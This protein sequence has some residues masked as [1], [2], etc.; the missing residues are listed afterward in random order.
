MESREQLFHQVHFFE[1][2]AEQPDG[3]GIRDFVFD[4][5][6]E[7]THE[8]ETVAYLVFD[9]VVREVVQLLQHQYLEHEHYV[10]RLR[11][12]VVLARF[13]MNPV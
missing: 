1:P 3:F 8:G 9:A 12:R 10:S 6:A 2:F 7:E 13:G 4:L 11:T 5:Q